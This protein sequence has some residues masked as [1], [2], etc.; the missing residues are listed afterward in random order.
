MFER[1]DT[2][3]AANELVLELDPLLAPALELLEDELEDELPPAAGT[4]IVTVA[5]TLE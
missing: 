2:E 4:L 3:V 5:S 1:I